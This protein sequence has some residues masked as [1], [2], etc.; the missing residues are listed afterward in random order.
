MRVIEITRHGGPE[1]LQVKERPSPK[2]GPGQVRIEV[3]AA[4]VNFADTLAR[5]GLYED[6]PDVP[7]AASQPS[8]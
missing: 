1:V 6:A 8:Q 7:C 3:A 2:A 4:G 5:I